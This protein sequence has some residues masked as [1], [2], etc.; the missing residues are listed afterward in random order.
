[1]THKIF[2]LICCAVLL[3]ACTGKKK[4]TAT[5]PPF[6]ITVR[7]VSESPS[8]YSYTFTT[9]LI[10]KESYTIE[11]RVS[12]Y[13][14]TKNITNGDKVKKGDL[15]YTLD[16]TPFTLA[17][18][19]AQANVYAE[20]AALKNALSTYNR[21]KPLADIEALSKS[22]LDEATAALRSAEAQLKVAQQ[23]LRSAELDLSYTTLRS[24]QSG[25]VV[26]KGA[27]V[28]DYVG[29]GTAYTELATVN[30][31]DSIAAR[32]YLPMNMYLAHK[33]SI[34]NKDLL[35][36]IRLLTSDTETYPHSGI[37]DYTEGEVDNSTNAIVFKVL[38]PNADNQLQVGQFARV[39]ADIGTVK[40]MITIPQK[41]VSQTL[42]NKSV[43]VIGPDST[44]E[45]RKV[46]L[47]AR[48]GDSFEVTS[49][50]TAGELIATDGLTK[51]KNGMKIIPKK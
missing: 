18:N 44:C 34:S 19:K 42:N 8:P 30:Q 47:G 23:E 51:I 15:L 36:N 29:V 35:S 14:A 11:P 40:Y 32:L 9:T 41:S 5:P 28:G 46:T 27:E 17:V 6:T 21:T 3:S 48:L 24:P 13:M 20:E 1:M 39:T 38:F 43:W 37:Y 12:A 7:E 26:T 16:S 22:Q 33:G 31:T 10:G 25:T 45:Y 4:K 50:L 49:G 2:T